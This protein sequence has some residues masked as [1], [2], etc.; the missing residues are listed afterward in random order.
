MKTLFFIL[1]TLTNFLLIFKVN[2]LLKPKSAAI[3]YGISLVAF[4]ILMLAGIYLLRAL[5][6]HAD[7]QFQDIYFGVMFSLA[8]M[9]ML[10]LIV[11][12]ADAMHRKLFHFQ[13]TEN[14]LNAGK[15]PIRF[16]LEN[17]PGIKM[18][19]RTAFFV[20]S[21]FIFYGIWLSNK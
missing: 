9:M 19:Y 6:F 15:N 18:I 1:F 21:I 10:N 13:E 8:V 3:C 16:A 5:D 7:Q 2:D 20:G 17:K 4:P 11:I 12:S 14:T